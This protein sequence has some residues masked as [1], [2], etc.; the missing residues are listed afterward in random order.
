MD[1]IEMARDLGREIQR[2]P[3]FLR[4]LAANRKNDEDEAL[5]GMIGQFNRLRSEISQ[6]VMRPD[7]D[8]QKMAAMDA[9]FKGLYRS[10]M[11]LPG[12]VEFNEAKKEIDEMVS[13][14]CQ[15]ITGSAN[16]ADPDSISQADDCGG[17]CGSCQ[18]CH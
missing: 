1:I 8:Q 16:G 15:I 18:G 9:E 11:E 14:A 13:F 12:M 5:Q 4:L 3:R 7:K 17:D 10:I 2:D 6:E